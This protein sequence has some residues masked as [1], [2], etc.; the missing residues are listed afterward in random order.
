ME[1]TFN[2]F[3]AELFECASV[4]V[5]TR[6]HSFFQDFSERTLPYSHAA[7][8]LV[9]CYDLFNEMVKSGKIWLT[10]IYNDPSLG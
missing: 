6:K 9:T 10:I 5:L 4:C 8:M 3:W 7:G 2:C 1:H